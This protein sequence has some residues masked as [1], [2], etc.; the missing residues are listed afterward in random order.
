MRTCHDSNGVRFVSSCRTA[1]TNFLTD[2]AFI[3]NTVVDPRL[4]P[5]PND[6]TVSWQLTDTGYGGGLYATASPLIFEVDKD[7]NT[8]LSNSALI[9]GVGLKWQGYGLAE[10]VTNKLLGCT[11]WPG[12]LVPPSS[13]KPL[14]YTKV[15]YAITLACRWWYSCAVHHSAAAGTSP[16]AAFLGSWQRHSGRAVRT[17]QHTAEQQHGAA[18]WCRL[19]PRCYR[20]DANGRQRPAR[21][22]SQP[23]Q[24]WRRT[25][26][27]RS[28]KCRRVPTLSYAGHTHSTRADMPL[29]CCL[30][31]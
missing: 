4:W 9:G 23:S 25:V 31:R 24:W 20:S 16:R 5:A 14:K 17:V 6:P 29:F 10:R 18:W 28:N 22:H 11:A 7:T 27:R 2:V 1:S 8:F 15:R 3:N 19:L 21:H 12:K 30:C 13:A 26:P